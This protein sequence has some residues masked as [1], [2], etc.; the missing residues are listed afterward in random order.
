MG[1]KQITRVIEMGVA[2]VNPNARD[3][4]LAVAALAQEAARRR[5]IAPGLVSAAAAAGGGNTGNGVV[6]LGT[7]TTS[8]AAV[9]GTYTATLITTAVNGGVFEV[10]DPNGTVIG[11]AT[12]GTLFDGEIRFTVADGATDFDVGDTFTFV[13]TAGADIVLTDS[14]GGTPATALAAV[15]TPTAVAQDGAA[16]LAPKAGFDTQIGLIE[17][18]HAEIA[19]SLNKMIDL[20]AGPSY[21]DVDGFTLGAAAD[22]TIDAITVDLTAVTAADVGVEDASGITQIT[23]ARN[24][25]ATLCS[26]LNFTRVALGLAPITDGS[27]GLF[28]KGSDGSWDGV[29]AAATGTAAAAGELSLTDA[30]VD[31]ALTALRNNIATLASYV[32]AAENGLAIGPFVLA[33]NNPNWKFRAGD[34]TQ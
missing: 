7:P 12:V 34:I 29:D 15:V 33:T 25:Q 8:A 11:N 13:V 2:Q 22:Q 31:A 10:T 14:S 19:A 21:P 16:S 20:I 4:G 9:P 27:G 6:T 28:T 18:A 17:D 23:T 32:N 30:S 3:L 1:Q 5:L 26:A 24:N